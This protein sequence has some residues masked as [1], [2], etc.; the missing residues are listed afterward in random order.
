MAD[1]TIIILQPRAGATVASNFPAN[2][3]VDPASSAVSGD[4][5][6]RNTNVHYP[7]V[8]VTVQPGG[9]WTMQFQNIPP[10][11]PYSLRAWITNTAVLDQHD[12][13]TVS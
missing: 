12:D 5:W 2:G 9:N 4:M 6:N 13:I 7:P 1:P 11:N 10:D 3:Q 8:S